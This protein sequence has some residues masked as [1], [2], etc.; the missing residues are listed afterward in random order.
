M[1]FVEPKILNNQGKVEKCDHEAHVSEV[2]EDRE[3]RSVGFSEIEGESDCK[4][5]AGDVPE[6]HEKFGAAGRVVDID[7]DCWFFWLLLWLCESAVFTYVVSCEH[8][9]AVNRK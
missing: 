4:H 3:E 7:A 5:H 9:S 2:F 1:A 6:G 8:V